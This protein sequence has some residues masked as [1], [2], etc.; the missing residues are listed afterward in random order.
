MKNI[1]HGLDQVLLA[2]LE[3]ADDLTDVV[4]TDHNEDL[5]GAL[6]KLETQ[7]KKLA[8]IKELIG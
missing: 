4:E 5:E 1:V 6:T 8:E 2:L 7:I 3:V